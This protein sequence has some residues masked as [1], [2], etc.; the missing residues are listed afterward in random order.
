M[1]EAVFR[2]IAKF[3]KTAV[4]ESLFYQ[5]RFLITTSFIEH[6]QA[7]ASVNLY[8]LEFRLVLS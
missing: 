3:T 2:K 6:L 7:T 8:P 5:Q 4:L 1:K